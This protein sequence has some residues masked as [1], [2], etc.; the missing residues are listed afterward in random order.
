MLKLYH[1]PESDCTFVSAQGQDLAHVVEVTAAEIPAGTR[2]QGAGLSYATCHPS[3]DFETY[4]E[5]GFKVG[6][7]EVKGV[8]GQGKGGLGVVGTANY[9]EHPSTEVICLYYDLKDGRGVRGWA[10]GFP[11][12]ADLIEHI[13]AGG[14]IEAFNFTFE[15][16]IWNL[17]C[18]RLY[19]WPP[20]TIEQGVCA[21]A[22]ARR[23]ALP[24]ALGNVAKV[25]GTANKDAA[26]GKLIQKLCRP[27]KPTKK[28]PTYRWTLDTAPEDFISM[29]SYCA[30]DVRA[31]DAASL[32][33]PD[34]SDDERA[35]W[36]VDQT[37]NARGVQ[38]DVESVEAMLHIFSETA[39]QFTL[40]LAQL[41]QGA[42]GSASEVGKAI[43]WAQSQ[44]VTLPNLQAETVSDAL[45]WDI[46]P[47]VRRMLE[48]RQALASAN[49]KKL[50]KIMLQV[51][52]DGR[53]RNQYMYCG[54]E[55]T[56][57]FSSAAADDNASNSQLQN[58]T[59]KGPKTKKCDDCGRIVGRVCTDC[60]ECMSNRF[61]DCKEWVIDAVEFAL[62][63]IRARDLQRI[64]QTWGDP[65][66]LLCGCLRGIF[67]AKPGHDLICMDFSAIEAV[68]LA[69]LS[70]CQW[71]IDVF[72]THGRIYE[73]SASRISG[74][75]F[76]EMMAYKESTGMDHPLRKS[77]GK[78]AELASG[79]SGW[80]GAWKAFGAEAHFKDDA[81]MKQAILAW[82]AASPE[83]VEL[84][85]GQFRQT[86][87]RLSDGHPELYGLEGAAVAAILNPG[88]C[89]HY[90]D[91]SY[92][93]HNDVLYC[94]LP[95]GRFLYYHSPRLTPVEGRFGRPSTYAISFMG[96]NTDPKKGP[97]G[98]VRL[99]TYGGKLAENVTQGVALDV[100]AFAMRNCEANG[101]PIVMH[102]H[103][104][105]CTEVPEGVGSKEELKRIMT[106]RPAW[107]SWWPINASGWRHKRYQKD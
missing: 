102:T 30:D 35:L 75:P 86:G 8:G 89:F 36:V 78:V 96:W 106:Q 66:T 16:Y 105:I 24:G 76:E 60:P 57:R 42:V 11:Y 84:W 5:A 23:F 14:V 81:E 97:R 74:V 10:P 9:A 87:P 1:H 18:R 104:E 58:I 27:H 98:W 47:Q 25:L 21:M 48:I 88:Q 107:A 53:L 95:S 50:N 93:V 29:Y 100:Q 51:S 13:A 17:V 15:F 68:V 101:Y 94:R 2:V 79:Y 63:D 40:E 83:I 69:C 52:S 67:T 82:R 61:T 12:P 33:I 26:G 62:S 32:C 22:K 65:V 92:A 7:G 6:D 80:I 64:T 43:E 103:D 19:G 55:R 91:I 3:M 49:V 77:L 41:T 71:R 72:N 70:R 46:P 20:L 31:E 73:M 39:R 54:A 90:I 28:R 45:G 44:G 38:V 59:A 4:S 37:V 99:E 34:L 56:G 85:G